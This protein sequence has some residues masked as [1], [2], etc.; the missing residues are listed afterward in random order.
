[1]DSAFPEHTGIREQ[2]LLRKKDN[3]LFEESERDVSN[4]V[5][6]RARMEDGVE[7]DAFMSDFQALVQR[8]VALEPNTPSE[9][10]LEIKEQLDRSYQ[11]CCALPGDQSAVKS[12]IRK[13]IETIM[14]AVEAGIGNDAYARQ[15]LEEEVLARELHFRLQELPLVAALTAADS[16]VAENEL[17]PSLLSEPV[18]TLASTLQLFDETQMA[19]I[20]DEASTFMEHKDPERKLMDA[21]QRLQLI[22]QTWQNMAA[23]TTANQA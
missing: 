2:H 8:S 18:D 21:W 5:L 11:Q 16:P 23:D 20:F 1:M 12:G 3:P 9:T 7:M 14:R 15:K 4:E 6:A 17:V 22:E 10:I 13:L 19:A